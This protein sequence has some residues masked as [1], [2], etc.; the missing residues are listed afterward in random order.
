MI[1]E[2]ERCALEAMDPVFGRMNP[3]V[4]SRKLGSAREKATICSY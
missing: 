2:D 1:D 3:I 4:Y